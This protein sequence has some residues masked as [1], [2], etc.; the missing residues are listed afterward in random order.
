MALST[1]GGYRSRLA[2]GF[3]FMMRCALLALAFVGLGLVLRLS[4][5]P[6]PVDEA[7]RDVLRSY[8]ALASNTSETSSP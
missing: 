6:L 8:G 3:P 2:A 4:L 5:A 1:S 7:Y